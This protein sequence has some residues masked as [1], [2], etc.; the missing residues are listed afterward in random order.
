MDAKTTECAQMGSGLRGGCGLARDPRVRALFQ[1]A[2]GGDEISIH[3][4][5]LEYG[6][7]YQREGG[8]YDFD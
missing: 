3:C 5:W 1:E 4:L 2:E 7:D 6:I 8:R